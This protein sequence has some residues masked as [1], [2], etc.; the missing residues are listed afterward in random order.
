MKRTISNDYVLRETLKHMSRCIQIS[1]EKTIARIPEF[2]GD[3]ESKQEI[4]TI[5]SN[6]EKLQSLMV[7]LRD[8]NSMILEVKQN[9]AS[10]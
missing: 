7:S 6:L 2:E 3:D 10:A 5:L 4:L 8:A 9:E 1:Q